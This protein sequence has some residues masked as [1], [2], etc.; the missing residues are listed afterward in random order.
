MYFRLVVTE[1][2]SGLVVSTLQ[3]KSTRLQYNRARY[4]DNTGYVISHPV[5]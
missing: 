4:E 1:K 2:L 3:L 5:K